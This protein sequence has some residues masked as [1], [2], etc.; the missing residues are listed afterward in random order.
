MTDQLVLIDI[1]PE[2]RADTGTGSSRDWELDAATCEVGKR[3]VAQARAA[4]RAARAR[5]GTA[6]VPGPNL[7]AAA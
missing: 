6:T 4:L 5:A 1:A 2:E 7:P 3:G